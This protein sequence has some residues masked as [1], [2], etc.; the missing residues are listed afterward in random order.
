METIHQSCVLCIETI[1]HTVGD[2][3]QFANDRL[4]IK[5]SLNIRLCGCRCYIAAAITAETAETVIAPSKKQ[6][7]NYDYPQPAAIVERTFT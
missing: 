4:C 5:A 2:T 1:T 3:I 7:K 6:S